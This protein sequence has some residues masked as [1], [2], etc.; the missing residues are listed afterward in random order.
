MPNGPRR[1]TEQSV[2]MLVHPDL[3]VRVAFKICDDALAFGAL[4]QVFQ[5]GGSDPHV[6]ES[7]TWLRLRF[8]HSNRFV[9][10]V[11][12]RIAVNVIPTNPNTP[13][14]ASESAAFLFQSL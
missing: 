8:R 12:D 9:D 4:R 10:N 7:L 1:K 3:N 2:P 14:A 6:L 11:H 5:E 13:N